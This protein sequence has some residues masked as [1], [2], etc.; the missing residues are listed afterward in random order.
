MKFLTG[1]GLIL[2]IKRVAHQGRVDQQS[3]LKLAGGRN[4]HSDVCA[5]Q[6]DG[7]CECEY[8]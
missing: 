2:F 3:G 1:T 8:G 5:R 4:I 6:Q 7:T